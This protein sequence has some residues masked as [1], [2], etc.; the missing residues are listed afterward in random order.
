[1][2]ILRETL[3]AITRILG[4]ELDRLAVERAVAGVFFS[5][6]KLA[7]GIAGA[8][9]T[10]IDTIRETF[11]CPTS[12]PAALSPGRLRGCRAIDLAHEAFAPDGVRRALGI[13]AMNALADACWRRRPHP[14]MELRIGRAS[15]RERVSYHV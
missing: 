10:P 14:E 3:E 15:C 11:C 2:T 5:G 9:A 8:C 4:P 1:M 12:E 7:N 6:V 13:A